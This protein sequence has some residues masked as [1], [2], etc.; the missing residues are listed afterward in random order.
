[1]AIEFKCPGC[2]K[3]LRVADAAAGKQARCPGCGSIMMVPQGDSA[4]A[5]HGGIGP[6]AVPPTPRAPSISAPGTPTIPPPPGPPPGPSPLRSTT[7]GNPQPPRDQPQGQ[8][9]LQPVSDLFAYQQGTGQQ[10][11]SPWSQGVDTANPFQSP[12]SQVFLRQRTTA[13]PPRLQPTPIDIS[14]LI[15]LAT[16]IFSENL[17]KSIAVVFLPALMFFGVELVC[18]FL[19]SVMERMAGP[20]GTVLSFPVWITL[21][22]FGILLYCSAVKRFVKLVHGEPTGFNDFFSG[23]QHM[24]SFIL[25]TILFVLML[26]GVVLAVAIPFYAVGYIAS[27]VYWPLAIIVGVIGVICYVVAIFIT[28]AKFT[29]YHYI[30]IDHKMGAIEALQQSWRLASQNTLT[31]VL[32]ILLQAL[33]MPLAILCTLYIGSIFVLPF[34]AILHAVMYMAMSGQFEDYVDEPMPVLTPLR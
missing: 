25:A 16:T 7:L 23:R 32:V 15:S 19:S 6:G 10:A 28:F 4:P 22:A 18:I 1:M 8:P 30:I 29:H 5:M 13:G 24:L 21:L 14:D 11:S 27:L 33:A 12:Q 17:G 26:V 9:Q 20:I 2:Q 34:V 3:S 31:T